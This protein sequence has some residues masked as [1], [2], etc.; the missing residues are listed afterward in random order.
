MNGLPSPTGRFVYRFTSV[1]EKKARS[2]SKTGLKVKC[3]RGSSELGRMEGDEAAAFATT[4]Y[5]SFTISDLNVSCTECL[6]GG[7]IIRAESGLCTYGGTGG[8]TKDDM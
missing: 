7:Q 6:N 4:W 3:L 8:L 2:N 1:D 5:R